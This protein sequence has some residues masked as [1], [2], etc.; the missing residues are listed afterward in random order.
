MTAV[1]G[2]LNRQ[3][4]ALAADSAVTRQ[5]N[6]GEKITKNGNK[7]MRLSNVVPVCV[8]VTGN[9]DFLGTPWELII[10]VYRRSRGNIEHVTVEEAAHDFFRFVSET[11]SL[12]PERIAASYLK[13]LANSV[14]CDILSLLEYDNE[15]KPDGM[16]KRPA[17]FIKSFLR[18]LKRENCISLKNG[19]CPL[20]KDYGLNKFKQA[21]KSVFDY[22]FE[23]WNRDEDG[24]YLPDEV[25]NAIRPAFEQT[26]FYRLFS[27]TDTNATAELIFS[28]FGT[29]E[30]FPSLV[31][32]KVT[33][34]FDSQVNYHVNPDEIV[35]I[36]DSHPVAVCPFAQKDVTKSLLRGIHARW[37]QDLLDRLDMALDPFCSEIFD[38]GDSQLNGEF[39]DG[40]LDVSMTDKCR[41]II[42]DGIRFLDK[43]QRNWEKNLK[44]YDLKALA[45]LAES[46]IDLTGF[47]RILT[48]EQEGVGGPVD[49]AVISKNDGFT[50]LRRKSWYHHCDIGGRYGAMGV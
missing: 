25:L 20:D 49:L 17:T 7:M 5:R 35:R 42:P 28:G 45:E 3:G 1:V 38:L 23:V 50:W 15:R 41:R 4:V 12:W 36:N 29:A 19:L 43:K 33:E 30:G 39:L 10:R 18:E 34:G 11:P 8:M 13:R 22:L 32:I 37:S 48:F 40:L 31:P 46:L 26:L 2:I 27:L 47:H 6:K 16:M 9:A 44:D 21:A 14:F 24:A